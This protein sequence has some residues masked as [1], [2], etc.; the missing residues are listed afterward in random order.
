M[1]EHIG[2][3]VDAGGAKVMGVLMRC[4]FMAVIA[5]RNPPK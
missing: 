1:F 4:D 5:D 2:R 3:T